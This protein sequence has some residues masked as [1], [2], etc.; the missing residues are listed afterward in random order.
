M[1]ILLIDNEPRQANLMARVLQRMGHDTT[2]AIHPNDALTLVRGNVDAVI[3][4]I[5]MP[6]MNGLSL[7]RQIQLRVPNMPIAFV[8]TGPVKTSVLI[9]ASQVGPV[10]PE[11]WTVTDLKDLVACLRGG[12]SNLFDTSSPDNECWDDMDD[13]RA[14]VPELIEHAVGSEPV[15][16][17]ITR[18]VR[19]SFKTWS[20]VESLCDRWSEGPVHMSMRLRNV[21]IGQLV[22]VVLVM[23]DRTTML[24][25]GD[26]V[27]ADAES[28]VVS[29]VGLNPERVACLHT[30][31]P[32]LA[33]GT[34]RPEPVTVP[35]WEAR[36]A[37]G[38]EELKVS[39][40][41]A[42]NIKL[43]TQ[44]E[45]LARKLLPK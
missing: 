21:A 5:D 45:D 32:S 31:C 42:G 34:P 12:R 20:Q 36:M 8:S 23:P 15:V 35:S 30:M 14:A 3:T 22:T 40:I 25:D 28:A 16:T 44:I 4:D 26:V 19:L 9:A 33:E 27:E 10:L 6:G 24:V 11:L 1:R 29:L 7:A 43:R 17:R 2:I 37:G 13:D 39:D 41:I 38:C 18:K